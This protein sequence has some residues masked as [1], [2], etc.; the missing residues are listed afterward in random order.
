MTRR[1]HLRSVAILSVRFGLGRKS[2]IFGWTFLVGYWAFIRT[3]VTD[4]NQD[5]T[6]SLVFTGGDVWGWRIFAS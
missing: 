3:K 2:P 1:A 5:E 4:E 6:A